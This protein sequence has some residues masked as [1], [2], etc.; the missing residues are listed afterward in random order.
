MLK[1]DDGGVIAVGRDYSI[2]MSFNSPGM[3]RGGC[4]HTGRLWVAVGPDAVDGTLQ[5]KV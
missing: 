2:V 4:D 3:Y 5:P 1:P